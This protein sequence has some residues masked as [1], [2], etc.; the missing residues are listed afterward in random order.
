MFETYIETLLK[1]RHKIVE[2]D[3]KLRE[4]AIRLNKLIDRIKTEFWQ[5]QQN[6]NRLNREINECATE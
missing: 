5:N 2:H 1:E 6:I 4:K 3:R